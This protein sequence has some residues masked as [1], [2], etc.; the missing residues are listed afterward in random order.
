MKTMT[1][2]LSDEEMAAVEKLCDEQELSKTALMKQALRFYQLIILRLK[3]GETLHFSGDRERAI[4]FV[5]PGF[6]LNQDTRS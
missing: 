6:P 3:S 5:G 4:E 2:N 1:L